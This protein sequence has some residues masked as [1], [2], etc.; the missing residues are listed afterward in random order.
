[1]KDELCLNELVVD[2]D[3]IYH[4]ELMES[5]LKPSELLTYL[6]TIVEEYEEDEEDITSLLKG[7]HKVL[8]AHKYKE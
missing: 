1:M 6:Y 7:L 4:D 5:L 8:E 2:D 3:K